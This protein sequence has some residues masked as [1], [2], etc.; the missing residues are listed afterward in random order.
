MIRYSLNRRSE[1]T[2]NNSQANQTRGEH[3]T[4][5]RVTIPV[6]A[7]ELIDL[8]VSIAAEH[9]ELAKDS[10]LSILDWEEV[11]PIITEADELDD[12]IGDLNREL[13]KLTQRRKTLIEKP[14]GLGDFARQSRDVLSG[15]YRNEMKRLGD[16]GFDVND[17]PKA[18]KANGP[19]PTGQ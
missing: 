6:N 8:C 5:A 19:K 11:N 9:K 4:N 17:S 3:M 18:K 10:P 12:K 7:G 1:T 13:E 14:G 2:N 15:V 16:F